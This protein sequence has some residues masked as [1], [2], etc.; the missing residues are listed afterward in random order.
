MH[1]IKY[2]ITLIKEKK[3]KKATSLINSNDWDESSWLIE[4]KMKFPY[5][6]SF[7]KEV[8]LITIKNIGE[9]TLLVLEVCPVSI[10][11]PSSFK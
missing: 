2:T 10:I 7:E 8:S 3:K 9:T 4:S 1:P 6:F 11:G 5:N